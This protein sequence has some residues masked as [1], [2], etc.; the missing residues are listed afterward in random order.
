MP[1][2]T[3]GMIKSRSGSSAPAGYRFPREVIAV[4]VRWYLR[5]GLSY[6]DVEELLAERGVIVTYGTVRPWCQKFGQIYANELRRRRPRPGDKWHLGEVFIRMRQNLDIK[7]ARAVPKAAYI[8][9]ALPSGGGQ[10]GQD[11]GPA[12]LGAATPLGERDRLA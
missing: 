5:Y 9:P 4:A 1:R 12:L 6:R 8:A 7:H 11:R 2:E 3:S 10:F